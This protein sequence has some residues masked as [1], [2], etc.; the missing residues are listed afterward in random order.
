MSFASPHL[1]P[2]PQQLAAV[3]AVLC[4]YRAQAGGELDGWAQAA[5]VR[6][7]SVLDSDGLC[8][9]MQFFDREGRCCWRLY[10]LPDT[11]SL[12]WERLT[13]ELPE[14]LA[15]E[16]EP[17]ICERLWRRLARRLNG[18]SWRASVLRFHALPGASSSAGMSL[19]A[20][21]LPRL[22]AC[23]ADVARGIIRREDI[24]CDVMSDACRE[25]AA[26][27]P[28]IRVGPAC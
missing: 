22:S 28:D 14:C 25:G 23:G 12:A 13:A 5:R 7:E 17:G 27:G 24:D 3:G 21:S 2:H 16:P 6:C 11:D 20:A 9:S 15:S 8:E 26:T 19:L 4:L 1:L 18:P 10:L